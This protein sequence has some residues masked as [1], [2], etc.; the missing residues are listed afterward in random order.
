LG[1]KADTAD[2]LPTPCR[3]PA[4]TPVLALFAYCYNNNSIFFSI[5]D[6]F[7]KKSALY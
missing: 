1:Q 5:A 4:D 2:T 7:K 3:H 6:T